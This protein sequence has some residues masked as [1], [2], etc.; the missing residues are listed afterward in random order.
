MIKEKKQQIIK[1]EKAVMNDEMKKAYPEVVPAPEEAKE[2][3]TVVGVEQKKKIAQAVKAVIRSNL[4]GQEK[5]AEIHVH[6]A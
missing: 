5:L 2:K 4:E 1:A 3:P 6:F